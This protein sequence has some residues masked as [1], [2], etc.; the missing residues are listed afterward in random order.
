[1]TIPSL[2]LVARGQLLAVQFH[3]VFPW[4]GAPRLLSD[5]GHLACLNSV[6]AHMCGAQVP[7]GKGDHLLAIVQ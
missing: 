1:M 6:L 2:S 7:V 5:W 4:R 3:R